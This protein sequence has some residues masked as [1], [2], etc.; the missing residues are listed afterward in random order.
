MSQCLHKVK[1]MPLKTLVKV[2]TISNLS[3]TRYC[4]GMGVTMIGFS[5]DRQ[6]THYI[7]P[8]QF[9]AITQWIKGVKLVGELG[10]T[11]PAI[12]QQALNQYTLDYPIVLPSIERLDIPVILK[13]NLQD[14]E[15]LASLQTLMGT[16]APYVKYFLLDTTSPDKD[17]IASL[18][19]TIN[20]LANNFAILNGCH[21][22]T[23]NL[24]YLLSTKLRG[25]ALRGDTERKPGY[26]N[27][28][29]W[30]DVL[31]YLTLE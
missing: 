4:A 25:I 17:I 14:N 28:D 5:L 2:S 13:L 31:E 23:E 22:A 18:Q 6:H 30:A 29:L 8:E 21:I 26:N 1:A 20:H 12:I 19:P 15:G 10:T 27:F 9:K 3:G 11:N 24:P 16:Y 7:S